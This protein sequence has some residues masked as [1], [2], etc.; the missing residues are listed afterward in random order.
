MAVIE[1]NEAHKDAVQHLFTDKNN[2]E[3]SNNLLYN[4]FV[5]TYLSNLTTNFHALGFQD[6]L[7]G[8]IKG[9]ISFY[10]STEEPAWYHTSSRSSGNNDL[11]RQLLDSAIAYNEAN[12]R[13]K[14]YSMTNQKHSKL[15]RRF[16]WSKYNDDRYGYFDEYLVPAKTKCCYTNAWELLYR[17][18]ML[19][20]NSIVRCNYL[21]QEHRKILRKGGNI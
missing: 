4:I 5:S 16:H 8:E 21:K 3:T 18:T 12:G 6:E 20:E 11:L 9:L 17:Q 2:T 13:L 1:L 10:E 15:L 7:T 14:F 19:L